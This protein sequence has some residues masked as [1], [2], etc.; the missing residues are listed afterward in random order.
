MTLRTLI[1]DDEPL[2]RRRL[3]HLLHDEPRVEIVGDC[4]DGPSA[5]D[6][7]RRLAPDL[8]FLDVQMPGMDGFDVIAELGASACPAIIFVTAF[9]RYAV[10]AFD[11][12]AVDYLLKPFSRARLRLALDRVGA[13][14]ETDPG[15]A[16][17]LAALM[18]DLQAS[19]P[20]TRFV[21][22]D[23]ERVYFVRVDDVDWLEAAGHYVC[24]HADGATHI[25]RDTLSRLESRL[26]A[27]RFVRVHR[28]AIVNLDHIKE[29]RAA[30]HGEYEIVMHSGER[31][32]SSR[33]A[34]PR[35]QQLLK[36]R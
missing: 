17:K 6:A 11:V 5:V 7:V 18:A 10:K 29:L 19:R 13:L 30:F 35:I 26:D 28:S 32:A 34:G 23:G 20:L 15:L 31:L 33:T 36:H 21:V 14:A 2:A 1:V 12:H 4:E 9:D 22:K 25:I 27:N 24:L 16:R 8:L 3:R